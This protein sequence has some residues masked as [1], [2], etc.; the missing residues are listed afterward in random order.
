MLGNKI[1]CISLTETTDTSRISN[2]IQGI[3]LLKFY[4][5]YYEY[6]LL[7]YSDKYLKSITTVFNHVFKHFGKERSLQDIELREWDKFFLHLIR[8]CP[9]GVPV[10]LRTMKSALNKALEWNLILENHLRKIKLPKRQKEEQKTL[11]VKELEDILD[12]VKNEQIKALIKTAYFTGL[13]L[14]E[15]INLKVINIDLKSRFL[16]VG[17]EVFKTKS[18]KIRE[19]A[20]S[21]QVVSLLEEIIINKRP[22]D[23]LFG[24]S[25]KFPYAADYVSRVFKKAVRR[26]KLNDRIHFHTCRH[27]YITHLANSDVPLPIVQTLAGHANI[28]TTMGYVHVNR[29]DL[30]KSVEILNHLN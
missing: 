24:K 23:L 20:M 15:L 26:K 4:A 21:S 27:S 18:R 16:K 2:N 30:M 14:S 8:Q 5:E 1:P 28:T 9:G 10:Y 13:R 3:S 22:D 17:D 19:V 29:T 6:I 25:A 11:S 7:K 12:A